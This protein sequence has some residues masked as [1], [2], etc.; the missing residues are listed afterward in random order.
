MKRN[1]IQIAYR[2]LHAP[3]GFKR[4]GEGLS[5]RGC[6]VNQSLPGQGRDERM[7]RLVSSRRDVSAAEGE[8]D[9]DDE[10]SRI[11]ADRYV[12]RQMGRQ[13]GIGNAKL[14]PKFCRVRKEIRSLR[15]PVAGRDTHLTGFPFVEFSEDQQF[16]APIREGRPRLPERGRAHPDVLGSAHDY[17]RRLPRDYGEGCFGDTSDHRGLRDRCTHRVPCMSAQ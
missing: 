13:V 9:E 14:S 8:V 1:K 16:D 2:G 11:M 7:S 6:S 5:F 4:V 10:R 15:V 3:N 17:S 12:G